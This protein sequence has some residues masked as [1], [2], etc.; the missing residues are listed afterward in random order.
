MR[1][2]IFKN[3]YYSLYKVEINHGDTTFDSLEI[4]NDCSI[5]VDLRLELIDKQVNID[6]KDRVLVKAVY[7]AFNNRASNFYNMYDAKSISEEWAIAIDFME[8]VN[9]YINE[10]NWKA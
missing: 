9:K 1:E 5:W 4:M 2:L 3:E 10:N 8:S 7:A 6:G